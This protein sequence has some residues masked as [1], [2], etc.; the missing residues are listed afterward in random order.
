MPHDI[1]QTDEE[2]NVLTS[3]SILPKDSYPHPHQDGPSARTFSYAATMST[4]HNLA[5]EVIY[6]LARGSGL[7]GV[8]SVQDDGEQ[9]TGMMHVDV[10]MYYTHAHLAEGAQVHKDAQQGRSGLN[11]LV[12]LQQR[13][14]AQP[15]LT[16]LMQTPR[17][18]RYGEEMFFDVM[19]HLPPGVSQPQ[20]IPRFETDLPQFS[21][22]I[23]QLATTVHFGQLLLRG[24]N[25]QIM[26]KV[27]NQ[28]CLSY[29]IY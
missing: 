27:I 23:G 12:R 18:S 13:G 1:P 17:E 28:I 7:S 9:G 5:S 14:C 20:W 16:R 24:T 10:T 6:F 11:I 2:A 25:A 15:Q 4:V 19:V 22:L 3:W 29:L 8:L 26:S 21:H